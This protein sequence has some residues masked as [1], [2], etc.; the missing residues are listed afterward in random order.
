MRSK[1]SAFLLLLAL[2]LAALAAPVL[3]SPGSLPGNFGD[4]YAYHYPIRHLSAVELQ[5][6]RMPFWNPYILGGVPLLANPQSAL[7]DPL[8]VMFRILPLASAFTWHAVLCLAMAGLGMHLFLRACRLSA[9]PACALSLAWMLCPFVVCRIPQGIPTHLAALAYVPWCWLALRGALPGLLAAVWSLQLLSGHPQFAAI[10]ALGMAV[11]VAVEGRQ[12]APY[13][14]REAAWTAALC[15]V[16]WFPAAEYLRLSNRGTAP[17]GFSAAYA[18]PLSALTAFLRPGFAGDPIFGDFQAPPS[19]F[20]ESYCGYIGLAPL[21]LALWAWISPGSRRG[22]LPSALVGWGLAGLG[23]L[24]ALGSWT[25]G[26]PVVG[27]SRVPARYLLL[28]VWGLLLAAAGGWLALP[29]SSR[30]GPILAAA[31][32]LLVLCDLGTWSARFVYAEDPSGK[33]APV[34]G[35]VE[36]LAGSDRRLA[37]SPDLANPNKVMLY[38]AMNV[39]GYE[40]YYPAAYARYVSRSE[41]PE[42]A[43]DPSRTYVR[44]IGSPEMRRLGVAY[45]LGSERRPDLGAGSPVHGAAVRLY[46]NP[47]AYP[48]AYVEDVRS[49]GRWTKAFWVMDRPGRWFVRARTRPDSR[50][51]F[52]IPSYPGW[53]IWLDGKPAQAEL[54]D[55]LLQSVP[56]GGLDPGKEVRAWVLFRPTAWTAV[57]LACGAA[58]LAW[59]VRCRSGFARGA[60]A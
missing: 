33:L 36:A 35:L 18:M 45:Y 47:G 3:L 13:F 15:L 17:L 29:R 27:L 54:Y 59:A 51:V 50:L 14:L 16:Q 20:F 30:A 60:A 24:L 40:A 56:L 46:A 38:R 43:V 1:D 7:F 37:T 53:R 48:L 41:A 22:G 4:I 25:H 6:G 34:S 58:W 32:L 49:A 52:S 11:Y 12:R 44:N 23:V 26:L 19:V 28:A 31:L 2:A 10:N 39:N 42:P 57:C 5:S 21:A 9:A 8:S 55:G